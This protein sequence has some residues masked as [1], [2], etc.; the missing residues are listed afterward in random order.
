MEHI[1]ADGAQSG[2][3][4]HITEFATTREYRRTDRGDRLRNRHFG[5]LLTASHCLACYQACA[6]LDGNLAAQGGLGFD[7]ALVDIQ[8]PVGVVVV[9]VHNAVGDAETIERGYRRGYVNGCQVG[10]SLE[11]VGTYLHYSFR[12]HYLCYLGVSYE[13]AIADFRHG[14]GY[15]VVG[16]SGRNGNLAAQMFVCHRYRLAKGQLSRLGGRVDPV[17]QTIHHRI[18][19]FDIEIFPHGSV[20]VGGLACRRCVEGNTAKRER[21]EHIGVDAL[22]SVVEVVYLIQSAAVHE[23]LVTY[24]RYVFGYGERRERGAVPERTLADGCQGRAELQVGE[25]GAVA[26]RIFAYLLCAVRDDDFLQ[27]KAVG[28]SPFA[29]TGAITAQIH[30][31]EI[32]AVR[33]GVLADFELM[34]ACLE[35][36]IFD[37][38]EGKGIIAYLAKACRKNN[39][40][41]RC[42]PQCFGI[43]ARYR[44]FYVSLAYLL[45][46][47]EF[48]IAQ[49]IVVL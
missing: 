16:D 44:I 27:R 12:Q 4:V 8:Q 20:F 39:A 34:T 7:K 37:R 30:F 36:H 17:I 5:Y 31:F 21:A 33:E 26:E 11:A 41:Y 15:G 10:H 28:E 47:Y 19:L 23:R 13:C 18:Q 25:F 29:Q 42:I 46:Q 38:G 22:R 9:V 2:R 14:I 35:H 48:Y 45:R 3:Q 1:L 49:M 6:I 24:R 40:L 32:S 43:N